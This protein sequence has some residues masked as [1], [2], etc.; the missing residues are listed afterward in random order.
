MVKRIEGLSEINK[1]KSSEL[2]VVRISTNTVGENVT[3]KFVE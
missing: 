3:A 1:N 2:P